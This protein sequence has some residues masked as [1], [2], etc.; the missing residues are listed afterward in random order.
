[1]NLL[2]CF[3]WL[4]LSQNVFAQEVDV[5]G[6]VLNSDRRPISGAVAINE[7]GQTISDTTDA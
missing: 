1:M 6:E 3:V 4:L 2:L 5:T 7:R